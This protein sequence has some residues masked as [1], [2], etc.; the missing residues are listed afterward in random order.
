MND[1]TP[2][3]K[4]HNRQGPLDWWVGCREHGIASESGCWSCLVVA[5]LNGQFAKQLEDES[6]QERRGAA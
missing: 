5:H 4:R 6:A 2:A 3:W 1:D